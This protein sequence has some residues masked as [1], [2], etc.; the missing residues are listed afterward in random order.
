MGLPQVSSGCIA[1]EV[2]GSLGTFVQTARKNVLELS[3]ESHISNTFKDDKSNI[4]KLKIDSM[5][6]IGR[7][8]VNSDQIMQTPTSRTIGFQIRPL[9]PHVS[10]NGYLS[11]EFNVTDDATEVSASQVRKRLFSPLNGA[12]LTDH[13]K[14]DKKVHI[15]N[16]N[17][18]H[19]TIWSSSCFQE[20]ISCKHFKASP[21]LNES[22][23]ATITNC[24][25]AALSIPQTNVSSPRFPLSPLGKKFYT[26]KKLGGCRGI[27]IM[28]DDDNLTFNDVEQS[29]D[30]TFLGILSAHETPNKSKLNSNSIQQN[31]DL[32]TPDN[33]IDV[34]DCWTHSASFPP[35]HAKL[36]RSVNRLPIRRSL[37][38]SFEESLLSGRLMS[39]K[40]HQVGIILMYES[41]LVSIMSY[42]SVI[43]LCYCTTFNFAEI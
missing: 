35:R 37:V 16:Y 3:K 12:L 32:F 40:V 30:R 7:L 1:E 22:E 29:L 4:Q 18:I 10:G 19:S 5:E 33:I 25:T 26:N 24:Q 17:N 36:C 14:G 43:L 6:Q 39:E 11:T 8:S 31:F 27:D 15:G 9:T 23:E 42:L 20:P 2:T 41:H 34:N 21:A 13:F 38:G 28:L